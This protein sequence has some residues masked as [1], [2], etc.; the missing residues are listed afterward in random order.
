MKKNL[1]L[2]GMMGVG[3]STLAK[4]LAEKYKFELIDID[5]KIEEANSMSIREIFEKKGENFFRLEEEK[6]TLNSLDK[7]GC[8][9]A[10]GGGAFINEKIRDKVLNNSISFWLDASINLISER[11][12]KKGNLKRPMLNK[13][14]IKE[15]LKKIYEKRKKIYNLASYKIS[16]DKLSLKEI[17]KKIMVVYE[18][19]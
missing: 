6:I 7:T 4:L 5:Q 8:V 10:L 13:G 12:E 17:S 9:I 18:S 16:C 19:Q 1:V 11:L 15:N 3:K 14:G 2:L